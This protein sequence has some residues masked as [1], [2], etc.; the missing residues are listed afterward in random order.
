MSGRSLSAA[1]ASALDAAHVTWFPLVELSLSSGTQY[2]CGAGHDVAWNGN[3]YLSLL[4]LGSIEPVVE[5]DSEQPGLV[6]TISGVPQSTIALAL[7]EDVQGRAVTLRMATLDSAGA[8]QVDANAW[9]GLLD[10]LTSEDAAP[11]ATVRV[12]AEHILIAW[13]EA[14]GLRMSDQDQQRLH[15]GD[16]F[17]EYQSSLVEATI[18]WPT[19]AAQGG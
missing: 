8:L 19:K 7:T 10:V 1:V 6:F 9:Q 11:T 14:A 16:L 4:G 15:P 18:V 5:T 3:T 13:E 12:S 17:F 2:L